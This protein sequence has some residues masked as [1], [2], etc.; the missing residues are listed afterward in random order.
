MMKAGAEK[1]STPID[2][3]VGIETCRLLD[4]LLSAD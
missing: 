2:I 4:D 3:N 1:T